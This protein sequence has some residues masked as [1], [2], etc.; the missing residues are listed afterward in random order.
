MPIKNDDTVQVHYT[1]TLE[2]GSVFD[3]S[4][5]REPL[6]F[7]MGQGMLIAG[8]ENAVVGKEVGDKVKVTIPPAEAYGEMD[9]ELIFTV[10]RSEVPEHIIPEVGMELSLSNEDGGMNV[11]VHE[12]TDEYVSL[13]A[14]HPLAGKTLLFDIEIV[15]IK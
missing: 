9:E 3:S 2:D 10:P 14:N 8:F 12:V 4:L 5:E 15:A 1:G 13:N 7:T 6:E 11:Q